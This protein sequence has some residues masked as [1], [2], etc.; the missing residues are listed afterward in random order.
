MRKL[1]L[2]HPSG[3]T[4][5]SQLPANQE[6]SSESR[7]LDEE[8]LVPGPRIHCE[9]AVLC[10]SRSYRSSKDTP[11]YNL[12]SAVLKSALQDVSIRDKSSPLYRDAYKWFTE[13][14]PYTGAYQQHVFSIESICLYLKVDKKTVQRHVREKYASK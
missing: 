2:H 9:S 10:S 3:E 13:T 11:Y 6:Q 12:M 5:Y 8:I 4:G 14:F 7:A 1:P